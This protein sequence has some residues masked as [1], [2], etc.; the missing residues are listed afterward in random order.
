MWC[1]LALSINQSPHQKATGDVLGAALRVKVEE[2]I[3]SAGSHPSQSPNSHLK[4]TGKT[5]NF[6]V[7]TEENPLSSP[8]RGFVSRG[9][10]VG[11]EGFRTAL[12]VRPAGR[13]ARSRRDAWYPPAAPSTGPGGRG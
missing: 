6:A 12:G 7:A 5:R 8:W 1:S 9:A 13:E 4:V 11:G 3:L 10:G 2:E